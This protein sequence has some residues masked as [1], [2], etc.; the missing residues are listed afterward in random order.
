MSMSMSMSISLS[1]T[2]ALPLSLEGLAKG[3]LTARPLPLSKT[4][5]GGVETPINRGAKQS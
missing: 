5:E 2:L 4:F 3:G 1:W